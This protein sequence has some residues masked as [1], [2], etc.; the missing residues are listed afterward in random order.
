MK[1]SAPKRLWFRCSRSYQKAKGIISLISKALEVAIRLC[2]LNAV[3]L[4][5]AI[6]WDCEGIFQI[7]FWTVLLCMAQLCQQGFICTPTSRVLP[8]TSNQTTATPIFG[9]D[10]PFHPFR[11]VQPV[12]S[13][14]FFKAQFL[15]PAL[16]NSC[17]APSK[18][19]LTSLKLTT[20][21]LCSSLLVRTTFSSL[22]AS[23]LFRQP[24]T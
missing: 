12:N 10:S 4:S 18:P 6:H 8:H 24:M 5:A 22:P 21:T 17:H 13:L 19:L 9:S 3:I 16:I 20:S 1:Q 11:Q 7:C 2:S 15:R 23:N 14:L